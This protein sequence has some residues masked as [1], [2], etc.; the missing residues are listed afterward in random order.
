METKEKIRKKCDMLL[1]LRGFRNIL[2]HEYAEVNNERAFELITDMIEGYKIFVKE[3]V[4]SL[5]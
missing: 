3:V 1:E 5:K 2:V 4:T